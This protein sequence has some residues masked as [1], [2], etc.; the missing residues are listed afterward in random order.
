MQ[1]VV[2]SIPFA[3]TSPD[4]RVSSP[5]APRVGTEGQG[6]ATQPAWRRRKPAGGVAPGSGYSHT[7]ATPGIR[8]GALA[9]R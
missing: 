9:T 1:E 4:L 7:S 6:V 5:E 3:S 8:V 2:G